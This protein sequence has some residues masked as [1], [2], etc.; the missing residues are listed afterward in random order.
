MKYLK[1]SNFLILIV[2][3][4]I[5]LLTSCKT[6]D[7]K[8]NTIDMIKT[9]TLGLAYLEENK[10]PEAEAT[11]KQLIEI[12]PEEALG[13][14]N[15]ALVYIRFG[16]FEQS[17]ILFKQAL[18]IDPE[19]PGIYLNY[20]EL[21]FMTDRNEL[22]VEIL[23]KSLRQNPDH[24]R[25][26]YKLGHTF[27]QSNDKQIRFRAEELL[28]KVVTFLP[29]NITARLELVDVLLRE[30]KSDL[31]NRKCRNFLKVLMSSI[32]RHLL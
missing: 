29:I 31:A 22:A 9:R 12:A 4:L 7:Q 30:G 32:R 18:D 26:L 6:G 14:T 10:L 25:T 13:Y 8:K 11:F 3:L 17:E 24:I 20:A 28:R 27:A 21:L 2:I 1:Q 23:E 16:N 5:F 19:N 15:L